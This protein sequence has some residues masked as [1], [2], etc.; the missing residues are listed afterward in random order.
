MSLRA[1]RP[2]QRETQLVPE[3][4]Q[5]AQRG[6]Q[7]VPVRNTACAARNTACAAR[8]AACAEGNTACARRNAACA[9]RNAGCGDRNAAREQEEQ[10][11]M[12]RSKSPRARRPPV[13]SRSSLT[14]GCSDGRRRFHRPV[15]E[16]RFPLAPLAQRPC[17]SGSPSAPTRRGPTLSNMGLTTWKGDLVR[18]SD[19]A[20]PRSE[21]SLR[22]HLARRI[23]RDG[24]GI[25]GSCFPRPFHSS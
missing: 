21:S 3:R 7:L 5:V 2:G 15:R 6:T 1:T 11:S 25:L 16:W 17:P 8:N 24:G 12:G 22:E 20:M 9:A 19:V 13:D 10:R 4:T 18:K 14:S 23:V